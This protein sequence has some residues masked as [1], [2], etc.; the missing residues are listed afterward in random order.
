LTCVK[1]FYSKDT[2]K[3]NFMLE[4]D[5]CTYNAFEKGILRS[6]TT[7]EK[8]MNTSYSLL[9]KAGGSVIYR[10]LMG[11]HST[12]MIEAIE[13]S[14]LLLLTA[15]AREELMNALPVLNATKDCC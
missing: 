6:Y 1:L 3:T 9:L 5:I 11:K 8:G 10:V 13:D 4:G 2:E 7:D 14:E 15:S 12:Y